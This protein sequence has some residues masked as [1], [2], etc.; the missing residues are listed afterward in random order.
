MGYVV[1]ATVVQQDSTV[2]IVTSWQ[3]PG[4]FITIILPKTCPS[5]GML[6]MM[7]LKALFCLTVEKRIVL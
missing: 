6:M 5:F 4:F 7:M 1:G 3:G 2:S